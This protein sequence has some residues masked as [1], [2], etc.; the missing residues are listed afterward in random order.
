VLGM[1]D[2]PGGP[3][4]RRLQETFFKRETSPQTAA[5]VL[6]KRCADSEARGEGFDRGA[7][8]VRV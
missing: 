1:P 6:G 7:A 5:A 8:R 4:P 3:P 2:A